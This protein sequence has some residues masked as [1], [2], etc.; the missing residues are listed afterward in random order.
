MAAT[1]LGTMQDSNKLINVSQTPTLTPTKNN[2]CS[3]AYHVLADN[4]D[5]KTVVTS[6]CTTDDRDGQ[7]PLM[8]EHKGYQ[9]TANARQ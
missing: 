5:D 3:N 9:S 8:F 1:R 7:C 4:D 2:Y 6:N